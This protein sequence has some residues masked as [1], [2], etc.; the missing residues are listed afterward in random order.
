MISVAYTEERDKIMDY[1]TVSV[2]ELWSQVFARPEDKSININDLAD[3][4]V[5]IMARDINGRHFIE[6]AE[7][8]GIQCEII[9]YSLLV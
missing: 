8:F 1:N 6:T 4:P 2:V 3:E 9:E 7:K 5:A